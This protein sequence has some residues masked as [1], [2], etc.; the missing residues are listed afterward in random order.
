MEFKF[1]NYALTEEHVMLQNEIR[2][3]VVAK[4]MP[5]AREIDERGEISL[6][7]I[8]E[9]GQLGFLS[10]MAPEEYGGGGRDVIGAAIV[11]E[12]LTKIS[13]ALQFSMTGHISCMH[14]IDK[15]GTIEQKNKYISKLASGEYIGGIGI[16]EPEIGL[17]IV[18]LKTDAIKNGNHFILNG[19]KKFILNGNIADVIIAMARTGEKNGISNFIIETNNP[20]YSSS[21]PIEKMGNRAAPVCDVILYDYK[22]P[23]GNKLGSLN[24][25]KVEAANILP[26]IQMFIVIM[27]GALSEVSF[28]EAL[29]YSL[30]RKQFG[31]QIVQFQMVQHMIA[32]MAVGTQVIKAM[33]ENCLKKYAEGVD[34]NT[35]ASM[36]KLYS[37]DAVTNIT[38]NG[39]Q[40]LGGYGYTR[41]F[42]VERFFRDA[43]L[44]SIVGG[45]SRVQ[46]Q[47]I[48]QS[49]LFD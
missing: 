11:A 15:Y 4:L 12:E 37:T 30:Q 46:D 32:D 42:P 38:L 19:K 48:S 44:L 31:S 18:S 34:I 14:W 1:I 17:D 36:A 22:V 40:I 41:E 25:G 5:I 45:S 47:L 28:R 24:N 20:G 6:D 23:S 39:I 13:A 43:A 9:I 10:L 29:N 49:I 21:K 33:V 35:D 8:K 3:I 7:F 27:C 16:N 2:K 26:F